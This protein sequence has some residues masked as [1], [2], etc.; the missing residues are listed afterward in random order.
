MTVGG[1]PIYGSDAIAGTVNVILKKNF[2]GLEGSV[3]SGISKY[4]DGGDINGSLLFGKNFAGGR[5]NITINAYY[6]RQHGITGAQRPDSYGGSA[7]FFGT[8]ADSSVPYI[9]Q[10]YSGGLHYNIFTNTG[11]PLFA[12]SIP[13]YG[14]QPYAGITNAAGQA[15]RFNNAGKLVPFVNG[16]ITG[17]GLYQAGGDGFP[18]GDYSNFLA[19]TE[20]YALT[21]LTHYDI[22]DHVTF[23]GEVWWGRS[24]GTDLS[25][26]PAYSTALFANAGQANGNL[27]LSSSN[28]FLSAAD[29]ATIEAGLGG[30]GDFYLARANTDLQGGS[31]KTRSDI[32]RLVGGLK[33]DFAAGERKFNWDITLTYGR[34]TSQTVT[35]EINFQNFT[36]ALNA[37]TGPD[38][39]PACASG[40][41]NS[42]FA[43]LSSTCAPINVF[44]VNNESAAAINYITSL[45]Q[46]H[47]VNTQYD[48]VADLKG[49]LIKLPGGFAKFVIGYEQRHETAHFDP[50]AFDYGYYDDTGT[51]Q[52]YGFGAPVDPVGGTQTTHEGFTELNLPLIGPDSGVPLVHRLEASGAARYVN[53]SSTKSFWTYTYGGIYAPVSDITLRGNYTRSFRAP[54][55]TELYAPRGTVYSLANDPC[56]QRFINEGP[57]PATRA[58]NCAAAG[59]PGNFTSSIVDASA[60]GTSGGNPN[61]QNETAN[62]FTAG[63]VIQPSFIKGLAITADYVS[64]RIHNEIATLSVTDLM[65]ACYDSPGYP[66]SFCSTFTRDATSH[67]ITSFAQGNYNIGIESLQALQGHVAYDLPLTRVGLPASAGSLAFQADFLHTYRHYYQVGTGDLQKV[68][69]G[70]ADPIDNVTASVAYNSKSFTWLWQ[71]MYYGPTKVAINSPDSDYQYPRQSPYLMVNTAISIVANERYTFR[72][73]VNNVFDRGVPFPY[74]ISASSTSRYYDA[75]MGRYFRATAQF[76]F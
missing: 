26:Q 21:A 31:F 17:S 59:V 8:P 6:D 30:P 44:G 1:A 57:N 55:L 71:F 25:E 16:T 39:S 9:N 48:F 73:N 10:L 20:R 2:D 13:I 22:S 36:N 60:T 19:E 75:I 11:M 40:Y 23:S 18:I 38:G 66:N 37:V 58:A 70:L 63:T 7:P 72:I 76:K 14:G 3:S 32:L 33:G 53:N 65:D 62:S 46:A 54:A 64:I 42:P 67:Q 45:G 61:L 56:D 35:R 50:G 68:A 49:D 15:L 4:G 51:R 24:T 41:T 5:G 29:R 27:V 69:G 43:T 12:D 34:A 28:P 74:A 52:S 47:Q